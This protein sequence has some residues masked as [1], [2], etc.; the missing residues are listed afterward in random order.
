MEISSLLPNSDNL[1]KFLFMGGIFMV[2]FSFIYPL[3]K[4][5]K[6]ELDVIVYNKQIALLNNDILE[7]NAE[8]NNL[9]KISKESLVNL[10]K[11]KELKVRTEAIAKIKEIQDKYNKE[12]IETKSKENEIITKNIILIYEKARIELLKE[13]INDFCFF[14]WIFLIIGSIF[15]VFGLIRWY[16]LTLLSEKIQKKQLE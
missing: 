3:E 7:L 6:L 1:Y 14:R 2:V 4:K 10:N 12:F 15:T 11:T 9:K 5:Q 16:I 13:H 8:V